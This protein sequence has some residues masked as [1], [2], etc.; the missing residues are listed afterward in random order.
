ML[1]SLRKKQRKTKTSVK[2]TL[3]LNK[4]QETN[5]EDKNQW[6][7]QIKKNTWYYDMREEKCNW[8]NW[9]IKFFFIENNLSCLSHCPLPI[10]YR[11]LNRNKN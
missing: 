1:T 4:N 10:L 9:E 2:Q 6:E 7:K 8:E 5:K 11:L 3:P